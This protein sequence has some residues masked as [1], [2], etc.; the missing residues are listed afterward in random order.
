M[1][2]QKM[3]SKFG[4]KLVKNNNHYLVPWP[5]KISKYKLSSNYRLCEDQLKSLNNQLQSDK[6]LL[7]K[8]DENNSETKE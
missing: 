1:S 5:W 4:I 6:L 8:Y 2:Q 3:K 7:K